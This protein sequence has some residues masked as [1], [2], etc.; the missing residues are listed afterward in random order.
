MLWSANQHLYNLVHTEYATYFNYPPAQTQLLLIAGA[1]QERKEFLL[2]QGHR[3]LQGSQE[4]PLL[5]VLG[6][7]RGAKYEAHLLNL[8]QI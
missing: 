2:H 6:S 1:G 4:L 3:M 8:S 5:W 7:E